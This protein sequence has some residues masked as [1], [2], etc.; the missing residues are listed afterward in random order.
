ME[1]RIGNRLVIKMES[2]VYN[3]PMLAE[4]FFKF[5]HRKEKSQIVED[6]V[7]TLEI[8]K[9][10]GVGQEA[11]RSHQTGQDRIIIYC[12]GR[13]LKEKGFDLVIQAFNLIKNKDRYQVIIG[14]AGPDEERLHKMTKNLKLENFVHFPGW[15][16]KEKMY[17]NLG[18]AHIFI[19]SQMVDRVWF[20]GIDGSHGH[21]LAVPGAGW[22]SFGL[23]ISGR[24]I[25]V[26]TG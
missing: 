23:A 21:G 2:F 19:F 13:L 1:Q 24:F 9:D 8:I 22:W 10:R 7:N 16:E 12:S 4:V 11:I 18:R 17:E 20:G 14:G 25:A 15:L 6:M 3:T 26:Y 5:G